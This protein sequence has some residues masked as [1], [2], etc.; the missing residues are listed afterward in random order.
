MAEDALTCSSLSSVTTLI[1][2]YYRQPEI[3]L[4]ARNDYLISLR[5]GIYLFMP[6]LITNIQK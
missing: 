2:V 6:W 4:Y 5:N 1:E 3:A